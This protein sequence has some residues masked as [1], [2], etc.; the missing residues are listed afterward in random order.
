MLGLKTTRSQCPINPSHG[1]RFLSTVN[2]RYWETEN[3]G[4][5]ASHCYI[6]R[7]DGEGDGVSPIIFCPGTFSQ[8][9][10]WEKS[11]VFKTESKQ[12]TMASIL[13]LRG[14]HRKISTY[15]RAVYSA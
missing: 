14:R 1:G 11:S 7:S 2:G 15:L 6:R 4:A 8:Y 5:R 13:G 3:P 12:G 9:A 10:L